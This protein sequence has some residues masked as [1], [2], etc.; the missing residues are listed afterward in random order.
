M[1][2]ARPTPPP[3]ID[4]P[5]VPPTSKLEFA[6]TLED[7]GFAISVD[8]RGRC[9]DNIF[10]ERL[11]RSRKHEAVC[12]HELSDGFQ[13][14]RVIARWL[15]FCNTQRPHPALDGYPGRGLRESNT[16]IQAELHRSSAS[17]PTQADQ[18]DVQ[19]RTRAA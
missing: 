2:A 16:E 13:A 19:K 7:A 9:M 17:R 14:Q 3:P 5:R 12:L 1:L 8:G 11:W 10:I 4:E 6:A 18:K 15:E